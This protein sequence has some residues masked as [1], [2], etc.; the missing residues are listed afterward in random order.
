MQAYS[1]KNLQP[2]TFDTFRHFRLDSSLPSDLTYIPLRTLK[3][4]SDVFYELAETSTATIARNV[5]QWMVREVRS[6]RFCASSFSSSHFSSTAGLPE[7]RNVSCSPSKWQMERRSLVSHC[8]V[9]GGLGLYRGSLRA[10]ASVIVCETRRQR[11][12]NLK[13]AL[14]Q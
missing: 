7:I 4:G 8:R 5:C 11:V 12:L 3:P 14:R 2:G 6:W 9:L 1:R 10:T 13:G